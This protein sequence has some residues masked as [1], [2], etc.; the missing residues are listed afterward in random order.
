MRC[1]QKKAKQN[2]MSMSNFGKNTR[3]QGSLRS[4]FHDP[5]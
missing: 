3:A 1:G 4:T 2:E 5:K